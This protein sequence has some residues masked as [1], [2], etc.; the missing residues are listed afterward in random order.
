MLPFLVKKVD[1]VLIIDLNRIFFLEMK[2]RISNV[3]QKQLFIWT[4]IITGSYLVKCL[5]NNVFK[6]LKF[7][8]KKDDYSD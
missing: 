8:C 6:L 2:L 7:C 5:K 4:Q 3:T 1:A